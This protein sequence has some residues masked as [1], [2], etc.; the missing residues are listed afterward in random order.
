MTRLVVARRGFEPINDVLGDDNLRRVPS[1]EPQV[2]HAGP[3]LNEI[4]DDP[5]A[6]ARG[7]R[8]PEWCQPSRPPEPA[9]ESARALVAGT[10]EPS[11]RC[12]NP[13]CG[14]PVTGRAA[15]RSCSGRCRAALSRRRQA[16]ARAARD[17]KI[18]SLLVTALGTTGDLRIRSLIAKALRVLDEPRSEGTQQAESRT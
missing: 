10:G 1:V 3:Q 4:G 14:K 2:G 15:K 17:R 18:R 16:E 7:A 6:L 5:G 13:K 12:A 8:R 9:P 11:R